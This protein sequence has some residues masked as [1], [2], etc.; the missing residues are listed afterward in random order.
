[1]CGISGIWSVNGGLQDARSDQL[2]RMIAAIARRGPDAQ[3]AF[4]NADILLG[5]TRLSII[6]LSAEANQPMPDS[7][8][9]FTLVFNGEIYNHHELRRKLKAEHGLEFRTQSDTEVLLYGLIIKGIDFLDDCNGFF[10]FCF[11]DSEK[12]SFILAR[13]RFGIKPLYY[14]F[15]EGVLAFASNLKAIQAA[16][17]APKLD[18][19]SLATYLQFSYI[20]APHTIYEGVRKLLPGHYLTVENGTIKDTC[21]YKPY[22]YRAQNQ[23][24]DLPPADE[25]KAR[26]GDSVKLRLAADVPV[27]TFLSG[28]MDS[29]IISLVAS[30][31]RPEIDAFTLGFPDSPFYD[32][33]GQAAITAKFLG[34][35]HHVLPLGDSE[36]AA[37]L[38]GFLEAIDEPFADSSAVLVYLL[39]KFARSEVKV[40]LSGD[41]ADE[42]LGGYHKHRA[43][44]RSMEDR[45]ENRLIRAA[46]P[47]L[48]AL[49]EARD[50]KQLNK[51]R[52][53]KRY[54]DGLKYPLSERYERWASWTQKE[55]VANL[56]VHESKPHTL[57]LAIDE[58]DFN[59]ILQADVKLV[60]PNDMLY[61]V[62]SMSMHHGLEV[63]VPFL[64]HNLVEWIASQPAELKLNKKSGKR[65]LRRAFASDFPS[66]FFQGS[67][68]GFEAPLR[69]WFLGPLANWRKRLLDPE[70]IK[71]QGIFDPSALLALEKKALHPHSAGSPQTLWAV[72]IFQHWYQGQAPV[73]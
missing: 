45:A 63:R 11:Y 35:N 16:L 25:L 22:D 53:L 30:Q 26:L 20:M 42:I 49:P 40:V 2:T 13:D 21:Y 62:D 37:A 9:R 69:N 70:R 56:L 55:E 18:M 71:A 67:K 15:D 57:D 64:D 43:L 29:S 28:G 34:L 41:G 50:N 61:K 38:E 3:G 23:S 27:G 52:R 6:D 31:L 66:D 73:D 7:S 54:S 51:L 5:H 59:S 72:L 58:S 32:E 39:S 33:S 24:S 8:G 19:R 1:M 4:G 14:H 36:V 44:L 10:A 47:F 68:K 46:A 65:L 12:H 60:L 48:E 17:Q